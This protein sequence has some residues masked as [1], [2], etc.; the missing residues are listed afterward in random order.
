MRATVLAIASLVASLG[1]ARKTVDTA[2]S[3]V[4]QA[5]TT[6]DAASVQRAIDSAEVRFSA[7]LMKGDTAS[8][9]TIYADDAVILAPNMKIARGRA[10]MSQ[11]NAAM[12]SNVTYPEVA[13]TS[14]DLIVTGDYAIETGSYR[15]TIQPKQGKAMKDVGKFVSVWKRQ[16]DGS[17]KMIRDIFN[18]DLPAT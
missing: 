14:D 3:S 4:V 10:G 12:L 15:M 7:A 18:S 6:T 9:G 17:W 11:F 13:L 2:D 5:G 1:C 16:A 8:I